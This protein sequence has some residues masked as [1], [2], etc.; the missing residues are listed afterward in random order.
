MTDAEIEIC[1]NDRT[2]GLSSSANAGASAPTAAAP[3]KP[4]AA[5]PPTVNCVIKPVMTAQDMDAC[6]RS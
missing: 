3:V 6:R 2:P 1:R 5:T 4:T